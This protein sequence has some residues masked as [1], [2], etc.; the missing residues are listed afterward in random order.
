MRHA[1]DVIVQ[2]QL[3]ASLQA[4][5]RESTSMPVVFTFVLLCFNLW[6]VDCWCYTAIYQSRFDKKPL[7]LNHF[8]F[9]YFNSIFLFFWFLLFLFFLNFKFVTHASNSLNLNPMQTAFYG[10]LSSPSVRSFA[11]CNSVAVVW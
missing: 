4:S 10:C 1:Y 9:A 7:N 5:N 8:L 6:T 2:Y 3:S 11:W